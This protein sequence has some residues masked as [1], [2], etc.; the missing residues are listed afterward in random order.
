MVSCK[1]VLQR[2]SGCRASVRFKYRRGIAQR[3]LLTSLCE[4]DVWPAVNLSAPSE[5]DGAMTKSVLDE[6]GIIA[7]GSLVILRAIHFGILKITSEQ[8]ASHL[9]ALSAGPVQSNR[10]LQS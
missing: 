8:R 6:V 5:V 10:Y 9:Q 7:A 4:V 2:T 1:N 3:S